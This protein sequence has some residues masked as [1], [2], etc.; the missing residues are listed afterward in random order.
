MQ[1]RIKLIGCQSTMNE[2]HA[3]GLN[4]GMDC[5]FLDYSYHA[6]PDMLHAK[7]QEII[8]QSQD[9]DLIILTYGRCSN[10][11][12]GL[13]SPRIPLLFP[14]THDCIGLMLGSTARHMELFKE[15]SLTYYF[16]QGWLDYGRT[17]LAEYCEYEEKYGEKK[18]R[19]LIKTLYGSYQKAIF[20][21]TPGIKD[22]ERYRKKVQEIAD[23][24]GWEV[25]EIEGDT[26]LLTSI[27]K[28]IKV[29]ESIYVDAGQ[30][31]TLE[32]LAGIQ[33][34]NKDRARS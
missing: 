12:L 13:L 2:I 23:F 18:A 6:R 5:E 31:V 7:L 19:K 25:A 11:M 27:V 28:G 22:L 21:K 3:Q 8:N 1:L 10:S 17:P 20:I 14:A 4:Q 9:Y 33:N 15:N 29:P 32:I 16:S 34:G 26:G 30:V 24:F